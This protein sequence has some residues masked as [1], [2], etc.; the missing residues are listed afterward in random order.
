M[1]Q[2]IFRWR[3]RMSP[4]LRC[5]AACSGFHDIGPAPRNPQLIFNLLPFV[6]AWLPLHNAQSTITSFACV[7]GCVA[8]ARRHSLLRLPFFCC[9]SLH[10]SSYLKT[11]SSCLLVKKTCS[12]C[13]LVKKNMTSCL[14]VKKTCSSCLLV[15]KTCSS[16]LL[17]KKSCSSCQKNMA[18]SLLVKKNMTSCPPCKYRTNGKKLLQNKNQF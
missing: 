7:R 11:C 1:R 9:A 10:M 2:S 5:F 6:A 15:K 18:S 4:Q 16:C 8:T 14:L 17:V 12:S 13:L 3:C